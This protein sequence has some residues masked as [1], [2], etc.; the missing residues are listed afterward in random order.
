MIENLLEHY[1]LAGV[2]MLKVSAELL[3]AMAP[4]EHCQARIELKLSPQVP[5]GDSVQRIGQV[6]Q[7]RLS[8]VGL[9]PNG[10]EEE[11]RFIVEVILNAIYRANENFATDIGFE[12]FNQSHT[13]LTRQLFP[14]LERRA[15]LA[16]Q[17]LN[18]GHIRL[19]LDLMHQNAE[20][21]RQASYH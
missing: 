15:T 4:N 12:R 13:S 19:P 2:E 11:K 17:E 5:T 10:K 3:R 7:A 18:L 9:P 21:E 20:P 14:M 16:L 1:F 8:V 6:I